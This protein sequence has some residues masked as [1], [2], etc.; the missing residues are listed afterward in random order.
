ML[1]NYAGGVDYANDMLI[2]GEG[3]CIGK[4]SWTVYYVNLA[5]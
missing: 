3:M 2:K 1:L 4:W 5:L